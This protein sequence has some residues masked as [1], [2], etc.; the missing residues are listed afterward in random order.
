[1]NMKLS[2]QVSPNKHCNLLINNSRTSSRPYSRPYARAIWDQTRSSGIAISVIS[3]S[4]R[5]SFSEPPFFGVWKNVIVTWIIPCSGM[6]EPGLERRRRMNEWWL[7]LSVSPEWL[8]G[9]ITLWNALQVCKNLFC[10]PPLACLSSKLHAIC[11][12]ASRKAYIREHELKN[13]VFLATI[14]LLKYDTYLSF[15]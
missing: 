14:F 15:V 9:L 7:H 3:M 12:R 11:F 4:A 10:W 6:S 2:A 13:Y 8:A 5:R 1:M